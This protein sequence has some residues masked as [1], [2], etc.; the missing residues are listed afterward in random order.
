MIKNGDVNLLAVFAT[1]DRNSIWSRTVNCIKNENWKMTLAE[2][3]EISP[4]KFLKTPN[5]GKK[6]FALVVATVDAATDGA[7]TA[8]W[9]DVLKVNKA[10][11]AGP[12]QAS[13]VVKILCTMSDDDY[14]YVFLAAEKARKFRRDLASAM[15]S[16]LPT[17]TPFL[18]HIEPNPNMYEWQKLENMK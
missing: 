15:A 4:K 17:E 2:A 1:Q 14:E 8:R 3:V 12:L 13:A 18:K 11:K 6:S 10:A 9:L 16:I 5:F 7:Y